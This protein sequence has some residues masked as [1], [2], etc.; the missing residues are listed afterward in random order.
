[1]KLSNIFFCLLTFS[2]YSQKHEISG[3]IQNEQNEPLSNILISLLSMDRTTI[4]YQYTNVLGEFK[5]ILNDN[6][7]PIFLKISSLFYEESEFEI[8][9]KEKKT[10]VFVLK[11]K[12]T[13][14]EE[15]VIATTKINNDTINLGIHNYKINNI[16][17]V[18]NTLKK[19]PGISIDSD[20]RIKYWNKEIE[21]TLIDGDDLANEQYTFISKD[22]RSEVVE[23]IQVL[24]N[25]EE[26]TVFKKTRKSDKI[27]LN[28][29]IKEEF[30]NIWFGNVSMGYGKGT[31]SDN[32]FKGDVNMG[33]IKK[34]IKFLNSLK[35]STLGD[36]AVP[37]LFGNKD[38]EK[39]N[40]PIYSIKKV[41]VPLVDELTNFN[42]A[43]NNTFLINKKFKNIVLRS[44]NFIGVDNQEQELL[45]RTD[46]L[47]QGDSLVESNSN[48]ERNL[49]F[50]GELE[51]KQ[52][53]SENIFF[54]N[55]FKY[56]VISNKFSSSSLFGNSE[57]TDLGKNN[58]ISF[59][60][61]FQS[62]HSFRNGIV[63][64]NE[65]HFGMSN[66]DENVNV[67]SEDLNFFFQNES[68]LKQ[69]ANKY[70]KYFGAKTDATYFFNRKLKSNLSVNYKNSQE[71]IDIDLIPKDILYSNNVSFKRNEFIIE[72]SLVYNISKK[73]KLKTVLSSNFF[74]LNNVKK[75][76]I[77]YDAVLNLK[78]LGAM[79]IS[80]SK[81]KNLTSNQNFLQNYYLINNN[82]FKRG[83]LFFIP[84]SYEE[85]K[86]SLSNK[87]DKSTYINEFSFT[88]RKSKHALLEDFSLIDN[89]NF[90]STLLISK[91]G[92]DFVFK[93]QFIFLVDDFGFKMETT[94]SY[95]MIPLD[96]QTVKLTEIY[97]GNYK[98][99]ITSYLSS[100]LNF[101][102]K[103]EYNNN[104]QSFDR[105][106]SN[107]DSKNLIL[108]LEWDVNKEISFNLNGGVYEFD[109]NYYNIINT[110]INY[111]PENKK[112][113]YGLI[114]N[115]LLN[116]DE[117]SYQFRNSFFTS[118][119]TIPL[120]PFYAIGSVKYV[121]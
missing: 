40:Y 59:Y 119:T 30:K 57:T 118:K 44:T 5:F 111:V 38:D 107:F 76:L 102:L 110:T 46:F 7:A 58:E 1:M 115:N 117:F 69:K 80:Y 83:G 77:N 105:N 99:E 98:F 35:Y 62:T 100:A 16:E 47:I 114:M 39:D 51:L 50:F 10:V 4:S 116:E 53:V 37:V 88:Y 14:L 45:R 31:D 75:T 25:F 32:E 84:L 79:E 108:H 8:D 66:L 89:L 95:S 91:T 70:L 60:D 36:K 65:V 11:Q 109:K 18:E 55:K 87:N 97:N 92:K 67:D 101:N 27:A 20:G 48:N 12:L 93:D 106:K 22:L 86:F 54:I 78:Y 17:S 41:Q 52:N 68:L 81:K 26:N 120:I 85:L 82:T 28:L 2:V 34:K 94:Q 74:N 71:R 43:F 61:Y 90:N 24:K 19:I 9:L 42:N 73:I 21:K 15:V 103:F 121:F 33:L 3:L 6:Q 64:N 49:M 112:F 63:L 96:D 113:S 23:D 104:V 29:K 72:P 56:K 13:E